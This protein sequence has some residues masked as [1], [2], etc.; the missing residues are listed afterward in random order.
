MATSRGPGHRFAGLRRN[1]REHLPRICAAILGFWLPLQGFAVQLPP[2]WQRQ[3]DSRKQAQV[4]RPSAPDTDLIIKYYPKELLEHQDISEWL[5]G[6]LSTSR[7]PRGEWLDKAQIIRDYDNYAHGNRAFRQADGRTGRLIAVAVTLDRLYARLAVMIVTDGGMNK[8]QEKQAYPILRAIYDTEKADALADGRGT[9]IETPPPNLK[10]LKEGGPIKPGRY[11][12]TRTR[13]NKALGSY[14][15]VLYETGEYEFLDEDA[16]SGHYTYAQAWGKLDLAGKFYNSSVYPRE[17]YCVYGTD[18]K[19]GTPVIRARDDDDH[20]KLTWVNP[21]NRL[22]PQQ[23]EKLAE[24][25]REWEQRYPHVTNPGDGITAEQIETI[26][27]TYKDNY[28]SGG[29]HTDEAIYLLMKDGRVMDGIPVAPN[30]L[31]VVKSR[32]REPDRWGWWNQEDGRYSFA[33]AVDRKHYVMPRGKQI[34]GRPIPADTRLDGEWGASS[35]YS[36][37][38]FSSTSFWGVH[39]DKSGRFK[40]YHSNMMQAG[41]EMQTGTPLVTAISNDEGSSTSVIGS[42]IGGGTSS[43]NNR[44]NSDRMGEYRFDGF[45]LTLKFDN[46]V[47]KSLPVFA[48]DDENHGIWFDGGRLYRKD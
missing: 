12:G 37:L 22:S 3:Y 11:V 48:T 26:L 18:E 23:Q 45:N 25:K 21:V 30:Q 7:A 4:F 39:L 20:Y 1:A 32:S 5:E 38:D 15:V 29:V 41:G 44:P 42:N 17:H 36:S 27:Y 46:G 19:T 16:D 28:I 10:G 33:W 2:G 43:R 9:S 31:D 6:K 47:E 34:K 8:N 13:G 14:E 24:L 35:S 40:K